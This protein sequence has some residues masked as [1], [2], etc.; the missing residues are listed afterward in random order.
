MERISCISTHI[1]SPTIFIA[2][3]PEESVNFWLLLKGQKWQFVRKETKQSLVCLNKKAYQQMK[4]DKRVRCE[5]RS[6]D[7]IED[8]E[9]E[10]SSDK[11][12]NEQESTSPQE[13]DD[14]LKKLYDIIIAP[15]L[16]VM[17]LLLSL[18]EHHS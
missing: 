14:A 5:D 17:N 11:S 15:S 7:G 3:A 12:T 13:G 1:S 9:I 18:M 2:E 8:E 10:D 4:V 6:L 16:M